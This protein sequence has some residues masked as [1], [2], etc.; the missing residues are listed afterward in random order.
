MFER[1]RMNNHLVTDPQTKRIYPVSI[2]DKNL[3][4]LL[5]LFLRS[6]D[7]IW[8]DTYENARTLL[9]SIQ[10]KCDLCAPYAWLNVNRQQR[11]VKC[12][13]KLCWCAQFSLD[14]S[15][16]AWCDRR[17][18]TALT[19]L[20]A[21]A[22]ISLMSVAIGTDYWLYSRAHICNTTSNS[23]DETQNLLQPKRTRGDLT[24]S[25]LWKICCIEGK[26]M[27]VLLFLYRLINSCGWIKT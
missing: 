14:F 7:E 23:T 15:V 20:G 8:A 10:K 12:A 5:F 16:M 22:A 17:V 3:V 19:S 27:H 26:R 13:V 24:H 1:S 9:V 25:G 4:P 11:F 18:Q 2:L 6:F 21:L